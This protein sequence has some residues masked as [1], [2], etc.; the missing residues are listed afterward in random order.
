VAPIEETLAALDELVR[1]GKLRHIGCSNFSGDQIHAAAKASGTP[2]I[3]AQNEWSLLNR[4]VEK[5]VIPACD[6]HGL[7]QL[8]Y[9]PLASGVLTGKYRRGQD[10]EKGTRLATLS[11]FEHFGSDANLARTDAL[12]AFAEGRGHSLLELAIGWLA[13][14]PC[15]GSVIAGATRPEQVRSNAAASGWRLSD[16][17]CAEVDRILA[18]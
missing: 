14:Q 10:F 4:D 9:F 17:E 16:E 13:T 15:V 1:S 7:S 2:F 11:Y 6:E 5:D 8:P 3:T 12:T 18:A